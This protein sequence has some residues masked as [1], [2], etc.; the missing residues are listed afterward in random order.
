MPIR[1]RQSCMYL[2]R[3]TE[4]D[5][6]TFFSS[7]DSMIREGPANMESINYLMTVSLLLVHEDFGG[8]KVG[9]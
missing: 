9:T 7:E 2:L 8:S 1:M 4:R 5:S 6:S 3:V